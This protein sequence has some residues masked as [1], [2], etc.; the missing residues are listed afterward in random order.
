MKRLNKATD[1]QIRMIMACKATAVSRIEPLS[2]TAA[3][4]FRVATEYGVFLFE[5]TR[6]LEDYTPISMQA[7]VRRVVDRPVFP[8][9]LMSPLENVEY[10]LPE[11]IEIGKAF[12]YA[13]PCK[14]EGRWVLLPRKMSPPLLLEVLR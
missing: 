7:F 5:T 10:V 1:A 4:R 12:Q 6:R 8:K 3:T 11:Q 9:A 2:L 14:V 13:R